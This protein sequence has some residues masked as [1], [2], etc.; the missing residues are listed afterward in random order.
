M[1]SPLSGISGGNGI[2]GSVGGIAM[3]SSGETDPRGSG[4][5]VGGLCE[6]RKEEKSKEEFGIGRSEGRNSGGCT[7]VGRL[8]CLAKASGT[9]VKNLLSDS[10]VLVISC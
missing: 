6:R 9:S 3:N 4:A 8:L 2:A 10:R 5:G 1:Q 7:R